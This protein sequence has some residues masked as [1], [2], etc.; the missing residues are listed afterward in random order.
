MLTTFE[1]INLFTNLQCNAD[2]NEAQG[3]IVVCVC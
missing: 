3:H 1:I 2:K